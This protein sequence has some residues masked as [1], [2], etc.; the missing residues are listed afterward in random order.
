MSDIKILKADSK[1]KINT[2]LKMAFDIYKGNDAWV[3]PL[4][5][6][7]MHVLD[8]V[9]NP[10]FQH[11][12]MQLFMA[13]RDGKIVGRIAAISNELHNKTHNDTV[14]FFGFFECINDQ[15]VANTLLDT[16]K[17]W[18]KKRGFTE[19][20]GPANPSSNDEYGLLIDSFD[21]SPVI[22]MPFNPPYYIKLLENYGLTKAKDLYAYLIRNEILVKQE[23]LVRGAEIVRKRSG[24]TIRTLNLK[25]FNEE[26]GLVKY[27]YNKAWEKNWGFVPLTNE[28]MDDLAANFKPLINPNVV[29][30]MEKD[31][32]TIGFALCVPDYN[33][34]FKK[35]NGKLFP[36]GF[37]K[38]LTQKKKINLLRIIILG[39]I[40]EYQKR[41]LDSLFYYEI[42]KRAKEQ[43]ITLGEASWILED[44][45]MMNKGAEMMGGELY[46]KYRIYEV[47]I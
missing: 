43:G 37:I 9:K 1:S 28:E 35:M 7:K 33:Q 16:A 11:A 45:I 32:E 5:M 4:Y 15:D 38:L 17:D 40:P 42:A 6:D 20:R 18:L 23:K 34:V 47:K 31:G 27:V 30:F 8:K 39:V 2:F 10:F 12:E 36:F 24:V 21:C 29:L 46:R 13:E 25:K 26:L 22:S 41:G 14:G 44:N 3:P 19:M